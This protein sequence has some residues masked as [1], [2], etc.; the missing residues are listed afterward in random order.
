[1]ADEHPT[2]WL[3]STQ[4]RTIN[5]LEAPVTELLDRRD[6]RIALANGNP[7]ANH[8]TGHAGSRL[9]RAVPRGDAD[10]QFLAVLRARRARPCAA[11]SYAVIKKGENVAYLSRRSPRRTTTPVL[12]KRDF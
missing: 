2:H 8:R 6:G 1:M 10:A 12:C 5:F 3:I 11:T 7:T 9:L 4:D